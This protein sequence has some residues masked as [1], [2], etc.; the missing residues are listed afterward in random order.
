MEPLSPERN[1]SRCQGRRAD[2][3]HRTERIHRLPPEI[4][5]INL[6]L[7]QKSLSLPANTRATLNATLTPLNTFIREVNW[8]S[9]NPSVAEVRRIGEQIAIVV[10]KQPGTCSINAGIGK[11]KQSCPITVTA[12]TLPINWTYNELNDP[13]IPGS[14]LFEHRDLLYHW[15]RPRHQLVVG[16]RPRP[17]SVCQPG[18]NW[19][20]P[21]SARLSSL[22][23][24]VGGPAYQ[25]DHRPPSAAGLMI[26]ESLNEKCARFFLVQVEA[27]GELVCRWRDKAGNQDDNQRKSF[28]KPTLPI[29][30]KLR[31]TQNQVEVFTSND[32]QIWGELRIAHTAAFAKGSRVGMFVTS[33]NTFA[34]TTAAFDS[35]HVSE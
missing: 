16:A 7:D 8:E 10:A 12:S 22:P 14:A 25:W 32:D 11:V 26:R 29:Y 33:G 34:T 18:C 4:E 35:V 2:R 5:P 15:L 23:P 28:G 9:S 30:L 19:G 20:S 24:N 3:H 6:T 21:I 1:R 27:T 17:G 31:Q 13:P